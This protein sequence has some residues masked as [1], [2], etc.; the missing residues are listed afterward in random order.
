MFLLAIQGIPIFDE[1]N[2]IYCN[3]CN[4]NAYKIFSDKEESSVLCICANCGEEIFI[5]DIDRPSIENYKCI[6]GF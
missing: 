6:C 5:R 1:F 3:K 4:R 2:E